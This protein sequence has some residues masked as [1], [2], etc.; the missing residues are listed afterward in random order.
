MLAA[1]VRAR[2][3]KRVRGRRR[4]A[5]ASAWLHACVCTATRRRV[6][7][8]AVGLHLRDGAVGLHGLAQRL[9]LRLPLGHATQGRALARRAA[10]TGRWRAAA[11]AAASAAPAVASTAAATTTC[12]GG[13]GGGLLSLLHLLLLADLGHRA[14]HDVGGVRV[15]AARLDDGCGAGGRTGAAR[16]VRADARAAPVRRVAR[17]RRLSAP[18]HPRGAEPSPRWHAS[19]RTHPWRAWLPR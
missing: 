19:T 4:A 13:S 16:R 11:E 3:R 10:A 8:P 1:C 5:C 17:A 2:A 14:L 12:G 9:A 15:T 18:G 6:R 7:A